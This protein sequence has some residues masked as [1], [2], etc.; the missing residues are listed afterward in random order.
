MKAKAIYG[1]LP[2]IMTRGTTAYAL[3]KKSG[4][5]YSKTPCTEWDEQAV[6]ILSCDYIAICLP[7]VNIFSFFPVSF[8]KGWVWSVTGALW[9]GTP[10]VCSTHQVST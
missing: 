5:N 6:G 8:T 1:S 2:S 10:D 7:F 3:K 4:T 9:R